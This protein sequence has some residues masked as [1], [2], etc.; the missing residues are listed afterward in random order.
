MCGIAGW[1]G[2]DLPVERLVAAANAMVQ[3]GPDGQGI[4]CGTGVGLAHRR[5]AI[6][7]LSAGGDQPMATADGR[8]CV[9]FNGE[10]YNFRELRHEL[11]PHRE[12]Q[13]GTDTEV[14]LHGYDVWGIDELL[15]RL[16]GMYAFALWDEAARSLH[17]ARD[18]LG[19]KPLFYA[20]EDGRLLFASTIPALLALR[21][22]ALE[23]NHRALLD[24]LIHLCVPGEESI[25]VGVRRL[26]PATRALWCAGAAL[27]QKRFWRLQV[28]EQETLPE[29]AWLDRIDAALDR[30][31][32]RRLESDVPLGAFLSGG[33]DSS[34]VVAHMARL[35]SRPV[36]AVSAGFEEAAHDELDHARL[37]ARH[38]GVEHHCH[39]IRPDAVATLP[40]LVYLAGEPFADQ[41]LL[42]TMLL[43]RAARAQV[44]VVLTGDGGDEGFA[45]YHSSLI[46][47]AASIYRRG[48][49]APF[50]AALAEHL[51]R[52][53]G[54]RGS[55][56]LRVLRR[57][58]LAGR[59]SR[60]LVW[61]YDPLGERGLRGRLE[62]LLG[63]VL[64]EALTGWDPD[65]R[66]HE[67]FA[68][69]SGP[70]DLDRVLLAEVETLLPDQFL[71]KTDVATMAHGLEARC[72]FLDTEVLELSMRIPAGLKLNGWR[73][74]HLLRKL[75]CRSLP[76]EAMERPKHGF[77]V[78]VSSWLRG[79]LAPALTEVLLSAPAVG[80][81]LF[82]PKEV[83]RLIEAH[84]S[85]RA[86]HGQPLWALLI[87]ELW[88]RLFIDRSLS[89]GDLVP[90]G[91]SSGATV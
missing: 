38:L 91:R 67:A 58:A 63:P 11:A 33:V 79:P 74:K 77:S 36:I 88:F 78:P 60:D 25:L 26:P 83:A 90:T 70:S 15:R 87:L 18:P 45:G 30:A 42:P 28:E 13:S 59:G 37:V 31:V 14:L 65:R 81:G 34:L 55:R 41:A 69:A 52:G 5:L 61:E 1:C 68:E 2:V 4:W 20:E 32:A 66:W 39:V 72:P 86:D 82:D 75:A 8:L 46:A 44:T 80:R 10:I 71:V 51:G 76:R 64:R 85:G 16:R 73:T 49:P 6:I 84:R 47:R 19:K 29:E 48:L 62:G 3:R 21:Q 56:L 24:Y 50:R 17:L 54:H 9:V 22:R 35:S 53:I 40:E 89:A 12:F 57:V 23:V 27:K 7:D 43:A